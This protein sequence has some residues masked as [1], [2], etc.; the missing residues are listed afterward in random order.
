ME[1]KQH[2]MNN[3]DEKWL[4]IQLDKLIKYFWH[5]HQAKNVQGL[6]TNLKAKLLTK[7]P[8]LIKKNCLSTT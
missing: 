7:S 8:R 3:L 4:C 6:Q 1:L 5:V 2:A